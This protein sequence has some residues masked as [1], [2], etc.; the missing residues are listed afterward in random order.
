MKRLI[1]LMMTLALALSCVF[2]VSAFAATPETADTRASLYFNSYSATIVP[3][4]GG[5][6]TIEAIVKA[7]KV[8]S[9]LS[10]KK[11]VVQEKNGSSWTSVKTFTDTTNP[12]FAVENRMTNAVDVTYSGTKGKE[13][14]AQVT[15][16]AAD[17]SG[18]DTKTFTSTAKTA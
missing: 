4:G 8:M 1:T 17:A 6:I 3:E 11:I 7:K 12:S 2:S 18:S 14:R 15:V 10:I 5:D 13:Y 9:K 16:Y